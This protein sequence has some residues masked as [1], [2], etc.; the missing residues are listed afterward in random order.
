[1]TID[2]NIGG[3]L[4]GN[5]YPPFVI[6]EMSGNHNQSLSNALKIV[7]AAASAGVDAIKL[8]T[9]TADSMTISSSKDEFK[10][11]DPH[12]LWNNK[13]LHDLY[14]EAHTPWEWH[15]EIF[16]YAKSL[17]LLI[18]SSPF[19]RKSVDFLETLDVPCYKIASF[20]ITDL[21]L[22]KYVAETKKPI[23]I[24]TG[25]ASFEEI[26]E[27]IDCAKSNG[28][29]ELIILKCTSTYPA[30]PEN[31][32][33]ITLLDFKK[34]FNCH[35]GISDHTLGVGVSIASVGLGAVVIEKHFTINR[36]DGGVDSAFSMEPNEMGL[37]VKESIRAWQSVGI[38]SYGP[39]E[40]EKKSLQFR[41]SVYVVENIK[42]GEILTENNVRCIRPSF[43]MSPKY[44]S[45]I[46][47]K[48]VNQDIE[49]GTPFKKTFLID[50]E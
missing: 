11:N 36:S 32:N 5:K 13:S 33:I 12:S 42:K 8:Q 2:I 23:I 3:R 30:S 46:I 44:Y 16:N 22:I 34:N 18:F 31:T 41:R 9:Y 1:M 20:E 7:E 14:N 40:S 26:S 25:M 27:A 29:N 4:I 6:A 39:T 37:L 19:D 49:K 15:E 35:V 28:A 21:P 10:I 24:S 50:M 48:K 38:T 47:G 43:G 17:G 45:S